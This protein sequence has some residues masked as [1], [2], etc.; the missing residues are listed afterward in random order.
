[1][2]RRKEM[3]DFDEDE[4]Y[5]D[6]YDSMSAKG[7]RYFV[8]YTMYN[9][10]TGK[11]YSGMT[12][13][14]CSSPPEEAVR[15][16]CKDHMRRIMT[17]EEGWEPAVL[18]QCSPSKSAI[19]GRERML[20]LFYRAKGLAAP[21]NKNLPLHPKWAQIYI[22]RALKL[23]GPLPEEGV[24]CLSLLMNEAKFSVLP[25]NPI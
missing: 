21:E 16:R 8:T 1:M 14:Y 24:H 15:K 7:G 17:A 6:Y 12:H 9:R 18:D 20:I 3:E 19:L 11:I 22:N 10:I 2:P 4:A 25:C 23:F 5:L 13:G